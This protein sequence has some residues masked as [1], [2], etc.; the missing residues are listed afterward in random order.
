MLALLNICII[1]SFSEPTI[2][3]SCSYNLNT[4]IT[5]YP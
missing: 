2:S 3:F 5:R 4:G 1:L